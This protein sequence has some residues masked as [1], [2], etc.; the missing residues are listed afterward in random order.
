MRSGARIN[1]GQT[2]IGDIE[3][4]GDA[5]SE[6]DAGEAFLG[7]ADK[8]WGRID[9]LD[10]HPLFVQP[11][12]P[13]PWPA[14]DIEDRPRR[15]TVRP[16]TDQVAVK[17]CSRSDVPEDADVLLRTLPVSLARELIGGSDL[18]TAH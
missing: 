3:M 8:F 5:F 18:C 4:V 15:L 1:A 2:R 10:L 14:A 13:V 11:V 17:G 16:R 7:V 12:R 6:P 9:A